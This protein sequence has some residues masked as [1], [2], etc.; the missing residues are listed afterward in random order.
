M[1]FVELRLLL[2]DNLTQQE[3]GQRAFGFIGVALPA[4]RGA[5]G[6]VDGAIEI[7]RVPETEGVRWQ[8]A[9]GSVFSTSYP[10]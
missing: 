9:D 5:Q 4:Y 10:S 1:Q 8:V 6:V 3:L 2:G 7:R